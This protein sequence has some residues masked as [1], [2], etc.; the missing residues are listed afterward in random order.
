[1]GI[2]DKV[3]D[4]Y[5]SLKAAVQSAI[6]GPPS[7]GGGADVTGWLNGVLSQL[8]AVTEALRDVVTKAPTDFSEIERQIFY[9]FLD[10]EIQ[11]LKMDRI[12]P[13]KTVSQRLQHD[14]NTARQMQLRMRALLV[15]A[16]SVDGVGALYGP[17][18]DKARAE[19]F[20]AWLAM[21]TQG[22]EDYFTP[23]LDLLLNKKESTLMRKVLEAQLASAGKAAKFSSEAAWSA[24]TRDWNSYASTQG[25]RDE[26][27][28]KAWKALGGGPQVSAQTPAGALKALNDYYAQLYAR[29]ASGS[30]NA[31]PLTAT[32]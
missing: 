14:M 9:Q 6:D 30:L 23:T 22:A 27:I 32:P 25:A 4:W 1:M 31:A 19:S 20:R 29:A 18:L 15:R 5:K 16:F 11:V 12:S 26:V 24:L 2:G 17:L 10:Y 8:T 28:R 7:P 13:P 21:T 3:D